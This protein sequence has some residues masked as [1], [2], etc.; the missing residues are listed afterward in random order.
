[1]IL[2]E[3]AVSSVPSATDGTHVVAVSGRPGQVIL[4][5]RP[6]PSPGPGEV[7]VEVSHCG[8]CGSDL[9]LMLEGWGGP[10]S[11]H[12]HEFSGV[13]A[14]VGDGVAGWTVGQRIVGGPSPRC[15]RCE[16]C[17]SGNP[18]QCANRS[19]MS[20]DEQDGAYAGFTRVNASAMLAVPDGLS[21]R[22]AALAEPL[23][24]ALHGINR[25]EVKETDSVMIFG[26]GPIGALS[27]AVL[28]ARGIGPITVVEPGE[29]RQ[30][31]AR[32]LGAD[33]VVHPA[34][35]P[36]FGIH[37]PDHI[38]PDAVHVV[39]EC[40]GRKPAMEAGLQQLRRGGTLALVGA[41]IDPPTF[42]GNRIL[43]NELTICG[44]FIYDDGGFEAALDLLASGD[45]PTDLL[46][47]PT[48]V[49]LDR[50]RDAMADL[51][52]GTIAGKVMIVPTPVD[53]RLGGT[54]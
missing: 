13:I 25:A 27:I 34:D 15:G 29:T 36:T 3:A 53:S 5:E 48:D 22:E 32:Q 38:A 14:A 28:V 39:L 6:V 2:G 35:L 51:I 26:A 7:V 4:E 1:M 33:R 21:M 11:V 23:A 31:L 44:S 18:S 49:P 37:Q 8:I 24:V 47:D 20:V 16:G 30:E 12:G 41:G 19:E 9:H 43:L 45:L 40:S 10:G 50:L 54:R 17:L 52:A 46:I 42:D